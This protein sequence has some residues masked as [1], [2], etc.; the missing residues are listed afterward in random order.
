MGRSCL[1][2]GLDRLQAFQ[3]TARRHVPAVEEGVDPHRHARAR[4]VVGE[5][6]EMVL[7]RMHAARRGEA[8]QVAGAAALLQGRDQLGQDRMPG[9]RAVL[10]G[11]VDARQLGHGDAAGAEVHV[12]DLGIA[13]LALGQADEGLGR[14]DQS[15]RAGR[16]HAIVVRRP[17]IEDGVVG[18]VRTMAPAVENAEKRGTQTRSHQE[19][20]P[21]R[22]K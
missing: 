16:D 15:L 19:A 12:A 3:R 17:R 6:D 2:A 7:V 22:A 14:V 13:H 11:I 20:E 21:G 4:D 10:D 1:Q 18:R 9:E 8:Q 5:E